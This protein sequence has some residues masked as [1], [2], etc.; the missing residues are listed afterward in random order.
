MGLPKP[1]S[2][3]EYCSICGAQ[4]NHYGVCPN[5]EKHNKRFIKPKKK[6]IFENVIW[7]DK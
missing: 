2:K 3:N 7:L 6:D 4:L 1:I 5:L